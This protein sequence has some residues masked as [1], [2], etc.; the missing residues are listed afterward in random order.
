MHPSHFRAATKRTVQGGQFARGPPEEPAELDPGRRRGAHC[1]NEQGDTTLNVGGG[2]PAARCIQHR[3]EGRASS[4]TPT[5]E[6][7]MTRQ[8]GTT[9]PNH[10]RQAP[11]S[12]ANY[13]RDP[14]A[15]SGVR[16]YYQETRVVVK[17][18]IGRCALAVCAVFVIAFLTTFSRTRSEL[19]APMKATNLESTERYLLMV[20]G[21]RPRSTRR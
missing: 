3:A 12:H 1:R 13:S 10:H 8:H 18:Y 19:P 4:A 7:N 16:Y 15:P 17:C 9:D 14:G 20:I 21:L 5:R 6:A 11:R 2:P